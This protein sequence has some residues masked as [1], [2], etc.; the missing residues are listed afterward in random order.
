[1][2]SIEVNGPANIVTHL[3]FCKVMKK[4]VDL[5]LIEKWALWTV[6]YMGQIQGQSPKYWHEV[7]VEPKSEQEPPF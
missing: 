5:E 3:R 1:M 6:E 4:D 7:A 2:N